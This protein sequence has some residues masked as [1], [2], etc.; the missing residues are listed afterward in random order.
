M[1]A[2]LFDL[3]DI[4]DQLFEVYDDRAAG[5]PAAAGAAAAVEAAVVTAEAAAV[6]SPQQQQA[7]AVPRA[8]SPEEGEVL[9]EP[10]Q[11]EQQQRKD[12]SAAANQG[13]ATSTAPVFSGSV[14]GGQLEDSANE[15]AASPPNSVA[16]DGPEAALPAGLSGPMSVSRK[17]KHEV[18][19][20]EEE[21][22][23]ERRVRGMPGGSD[24][25][26]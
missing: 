1:P 6:Q 13:K 18:D 11:Q 25:A 9:E 15:L 22:Q 5:Q 10:Q 16:V 12:G 17:R 24:V 14:N 7:Q 8:E 2:C 4:Y 19:E 26:C 23:A 21:G 3:P 20:A